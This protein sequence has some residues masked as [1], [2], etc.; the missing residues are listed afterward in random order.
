[1]ELISVI[2]ILFITLVMAIYMG[3]FIYGFVSAG[4]YVGVAKRDLDSV[5]VEL[6]DGTGKTLLDL[7]SGDGKIVFAAAKRGY[8]ATGI[9]INPVLYMYSK[10]KKLLIHASKATFIIDNIW[11]APLDSYDIVT[12]YLFPEAREKVRKRFI[13]EAKSGAV[14][15]LFKNGGGFET[16]KK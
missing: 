3:F 4:P 1:M 9:E 13:A 16:I 2:V 10:L 6:N 12:C 15:V 14:L 7:G 11:T 8:G 5:L